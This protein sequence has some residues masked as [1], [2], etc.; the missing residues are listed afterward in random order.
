MKKKKKM[1]GAEKIKYASIGVI[2]L[3]DLMFMPWLIQLLVVMKSG[4]QN[5]LGAWMK[6]SPMDAFLLMFSDK[7]VLIVMSLAQI[8][9]AAAILAI[10]WNVHTLRRKNKVTNDIGGPDP[11]GNGEH[12]TSRWQTEQE[13]N[14]GCSSYVFGEP[15]TKGGVVL[16]MEEDESGKKRIYYDSGAKNTLLIAGSRAGKSRK[17]L[18]PT[19]ITIAEAGESGIVTDPKGEMYIMH[20]DYLRSKGYKVI[21]LNFREPSKGNRWNPIQKVNEAVDNN[22]IPEATRYAQKVVNAMTEQVATA[23]ND[24]VWKDGEKSL[25]KSLTMLVANDADFP[26]QKHLT[27]CYYILNELSTPDEDGGVPL[28]KYIMGLDMRHP[29]KVAYGAAKTAPSRMRSSFFSQAMTKLALFGDPNVADMT[30]QQDHSFEDIANE[31]TFVFL[32]IPDEDSSYNF[33]ATLYID[34]AYQALVEMANKAGG[35]LKRW[36]NFIV[37]EAGNLPAIPELDKKVTVCLGRRIRFVLAFQD[38][39]QMEKLYDKNAKTIRGNCHIW[40]Y[41]MTAEP[42]TAKVIS[43]KT[44][45][46]TI[47]TDGKNTSV[48]QKGYSF[49]TSS[50]LA[51]RSLLNQSEVERWPENLSLVLKIREFPCRFELPDVSQYDA[52]PSLGFPSPSGDLEYDMSCTEKIMEQRWMNEPAREVE[53][54]AIWIPPMEVIEKTISKSSGITVDPGQIDGYAYESAPTTEDACYLHDLTEDDVLAILQ[55]SAAQSEDD[56]L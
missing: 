34:Q 14:A 42:D 21:K 53:D 6:I 33:M 25:I 46:Y 40:I 3:L 10:L 52:Y 18:S 19:I 5:P 48:Q 27:S 55:T 44:G 56:F 12:G 7:R 20:A 15:I 38:F 22:N 45:D 41:L 2:L 39:A 36:V 43:E 17:Q 35:K 16:G 28:N 32:I 47:D 1:T 30:S 49:G 29:A 9:I 31:K 26:Q 37:D 11:A 13:R 51:K 50:T 24:P 8:L 23:N 4:V 54:A